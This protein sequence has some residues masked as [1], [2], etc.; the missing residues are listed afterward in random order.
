MTEERPASAIELDE[1]GQ[2]PAWAKP[3]ADSL[4]LTPTI[5]SW[6]EFRQLPAVAMQT[7]PVGFHRSVAND[8]SGAPPAGDGTCCRVPMQLMQWVLAP[9]FNQC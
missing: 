2:L 6:E 3:V 8:G 5:D 7:A 1:A 9:G 4:G